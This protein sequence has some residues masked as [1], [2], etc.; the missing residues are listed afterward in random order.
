[1]TDTLIQAGKALLQGHSRYQLEIA[2]SPALLDVLNFTGKEQMNGCYRYDIQF[3]S[4]AQDIDPVTLLNKTSTFSMHAPGGLKP[5][6]KV[7]GVITHF[8]RLSTSRDEA[9]YQVTL[10]PYLALLR[11]SRRCAIYQN[12]NIPQIVEKILREYHQFEGQHFHFTLER[13]YPRHEQIMQ[14]QQSDLDFINFLLAKVGIW[15]RFEMDERLELEV[16]R[17]GDSQRDYLF[18]QSPLPLRHPAGMHDVGVYSV[19][20]LAT[21]HNVVEKRTAT[22]DYNYREAAHMMDT[23]AE[24]PADDATTYGLSYHYADHFL[25][26]GEDIDPDTESGSFFARLHHE[27]YLNQQHRL[28]AD[29]T[30]PLLM[31]GQVVDI[32]GPTAEIAGNGI[33]ITHS[34]CSGSRSDSYKVTFSGIPYSETLGYR[35]PLLS[36]PTIAG[37]IPARVSSTRINDQYSHIDKMGRYRIQFLFDRDSWPKGQESLWVRLA[38]PYA[39]DTYGFHWPLLDGTEVAVAFEG[40]D[41][42]RPYIAYTLHDSQHPDHVTIENY[43]R[44]VLRTPTNNKLRMEDDRGKEHIK[45]STEYGGKSQLNLGHLVNNQREPRGEGFELRTDS[46]GALRAGC[47]LLLSA[48]EQSRASGMQRDTQEAVNRFE[49]ANSE[50]QSLNNAALQAKALSA[51]INEQLNLAKSKLSNLQAAVLVASAPQGVALTSG[52]HMQLSARNNLMV[53]AGK[54][55]DIGVIK[56]FFIGVG[57]AFSVFVQKMGMKL[58]ANQGRV[59]VQAQND[60]MELFAKNDITITSSSD[61]IVIST[62]KKLTLNGGGSYLTLEQGKIEHGSQGDFPVKCANYRVFIGGAELENITSE[63]PITDLVKQQTSRARRFSG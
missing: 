2:E 7:H 25:E 62:P 41:P 32:D 51:D 61:E 1:M 3:T 46:W 17:F 37:T 36:R 26:Q 40:G 6:R 29:S 19:W 38:K 43:R 12:L 48:D 34:H 11:H 31:P 47:G 23:E 33:F 44:N 24:I 8:K 18:P 30:S 5:L 56:N 45:L 22:R 10:E 35:P 63:H 14:W 4:P 16:V 21:E 27:R 20:N 28:S 52:E 50:M 15:Y 42:N 9:R 39:G 59:I 57:E 60:A 13:E 49:Q 55:A 53:N 54:N 58:I